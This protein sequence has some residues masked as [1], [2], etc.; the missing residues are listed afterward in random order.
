M[1]PH[2]PK[3]R[4]ELQD[5]ELEF[6]YEKTKNVKWHHRL[7][8]NRP[9]KVVLL[10]LLLAI[11]AP[12]LIYRY[13]FFVSIDLPPSD[14]FSVGSCLVARSSRIRC[15]LGNVTSEECHPQCCYDLN[16]N[17]CFHRFPSRFSY[18]MDR[19]WSENVI[20]N[21]RIATVPF[22]SQSSITRVRLSMD[23]ISKTH[24][25]LTFYNAV[26]ADLEGQRLE[27]KEYSYT[28]ASPELNVIVSST[29]GIIFNTLR[30]PLI[31]SQNIWEMT[32]QLT[33]ETMFGLGELPLEEGVTKVIY[34]HEGGMSTIPLIFAKW[35]GSYH[36]LLFDASTPT[37]ISIRSEK[38]IVVRS[39]TTFGLK[40]H[41]FVGPKPVDIM[42]DVMKFMGSTK[43]L[44][45][46]M[47]GAHVCGDYR[48]MTVQAAVTTLRTFITQT[49]NQRVPY[50]SHC[51][52][53]P[54]IFDSECTERTRITQV[55]GGMTLIRN[56]R[57]KVVPH[58]SPYIFYEEIIPDI[59]EDNETS[60]TRTTNNLCFDVQDYK[61][62]MLHKPQSMKVYHG[63][64]RNQ[65]VVYPTY[66]NISERVMKALWVFNN[67][68]EGAILEDT[69]PLDESEKQVDQMQQ[70][71]PYFNQNFE[72]VFERTPLWN[73]SLP[74]NTTYFYSHNQYPN[75]F[76]DAMQ[77]VRGEIATYS[78]SQ[79]FNLNVAINR[80]NIPTSWTSLRRE[81]IAAAL[82]GASGHWLWSSPICGDTEGFD[83]AIHASLCIK[84]YM[85][86]S[87]MPLIK[88]HTKGVNR[89][90]LS[91]TGN[92]RNL[93]IN[94]LNV[95][96]SL[97]PYFFTVL[98]DGP[99]LRPMFFQY[100]EV[101]ELEEIQTQFSVGDDLLIVPNLQPSQSHVHVTMPPGS[102]YELWSGFR[103]IGNESETVTMETTEADFLTL[104]R[105]GSIIP[106]QRDV[107]LTAE[108]TRLN[109]QYS[110]TIALHCETVNTTLMT[111]T[112][113]DYETTIEKLSRDKVAES[114][115][116]NNKTSE[117]E[118]R[119]EASGH[120][121]M[122]PNMTLAFKADNEKLTIT[123]VGEDYAVFC[124][125]GPRVWANL[126]REVYV[127]GLDE[128]SNNLDN[129]RR[130]TAN[131]NL[132][133]LQNQ[134]NIVFNFIT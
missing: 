8:L 79:W 44:R 52:I 80:Q 67:G 12:L 42:K 86:G 22:A 98:Q 53:T 90:P 38:L 33:N 9:S 95:R 23:E 99:L 113:P 20:M 120:L 82:G 11:A 100:P 133:T 134:K 96:Q 30:G 3:A 18:V 75:R 64:A 107:R 35:N 65:S 109:S 41:L 13:L 16:S 92:P 73:A 68:F 130:V 106:L 17:M 66:Q 49:N 76:A 19:K 105:G 115:D 21:P 25:S 51:G 5:D 111:T 27:D 110:I 34:N 24:L 83:S 45:Y 28:V 97:L 74:D 119:C 88:I 101:E 124:T 61:D 47:L 60:I 70:H 31:A 122:S 48:G 46:W 37:E 40:F 89:D 131:I 57:K 85:A 7:L 69:W 104:V 63:L 116:K 55:N 121:Y 29:Q 43:Q 2:A 114:Q 94:S 26:E 1:I 58:V 128:D 72:T 91:F 71:F 10:G 132:C 32:F 129:D 14:G 77:L 81:L 118:T 102:W 59:S 125:N 126:I 108:E 127:Y 103:I 50:D 6:A 87:Y 93:V 112:A 84:W 123:A 78:S 36:G 39:I 117:M 54:I 56:A 15:G 62:L 4:D